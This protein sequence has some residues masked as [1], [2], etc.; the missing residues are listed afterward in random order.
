M[1]EPLRVLCQLNTMTNDPL[2]NLHTALETLNNKLHSIFDTLIGELL[3]I[4]SNVSFGVCVEVFLFPI[5]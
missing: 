3:Q 2:W 4:A 5:V 1:I